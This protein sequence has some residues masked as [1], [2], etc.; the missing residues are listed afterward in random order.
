MGL[1]IIIIFISF[2]FSEEKKNSNIGNPLETTKTKKT[3][4]T[5]LNYKKY[6]TIKENCKECSFEELKTIHECQNTGYKILKQCVL[7][8]D[9]EIIE[10]T[11]FNE[12][13]LESRKI[14]SFYLMFFISIAT[15]FIS[16]IVRKSRKKFRLHNTLEK[17]T[18]QTDKEKGKDWEVHIWS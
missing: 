14:S 5:S 7:K 16:C 6:C 3:K 10:E 17:L 11:L 18:I 13:C 12:S 9:K 8:D 4:H 1:F 2:Y 15:V